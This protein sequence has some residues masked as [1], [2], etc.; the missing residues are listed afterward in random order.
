VF[1]TLAEMDISRAGS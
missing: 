1:N